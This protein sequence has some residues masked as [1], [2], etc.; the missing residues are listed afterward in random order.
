MKK[1]DLA[2]I[3]GTILGML[4]IINGM[5]L[6][7]NKYSL[8][9]LRPFW[10]LPS[11]FI[12]IG[13]SFFTI[14]IAYSADTLK[15]LPAS[16][17]NAFI[18]KHPSYG[19]LIEK[20]VSLSK[21]ARKEG[22]LSLEEEIDSI[23]DDFLK[24]GIQMVVDGQ[25]PETIRDVLESE[26][27][28]MEK[29]HTDEINLLKSWAGYAPAYGMIGTLIGLVQMLVQ[30]NDPS[31]LGPGMAKAIVT[32]FYGAVMANFILGPLSNKLEM[33]TSEECEMKEMMLE[34]ILSIQSGVNPRVIE[35]KL[36]TYLPPKERAALSENMESKGTVLQN[37]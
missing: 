33:K 23:D 11:V 27:S 21:K 13:G 1:R 36:K 19:M 32:S 2:T 35:D 20:F 4:A 22:L 12:T 30:L 28:S 14:M 16:I 7:G 17:K 9:S 8:G 15:K 34:G 24:S 10:D 29:R 6:N 5:A 18:I 3:I 31:T 26:V 37:E 25:E